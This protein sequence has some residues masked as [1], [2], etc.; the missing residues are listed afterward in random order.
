M[1]FMGLLHVFLPAFHSSAFSNP[2]QA[3]VHS[4]NERP[5]VLNPVQHQPWGDF[6]YTKLPLEEPRE[7]LPDTARPL[8]APRWFFGVESRKQIVDLFNASPLTDDQKTELLDPHNWQT[9]SNGFYVLPPP[10][11]VLEM[12][13]PARERIYGVLDDY[14]AN[15][16]QCHPFRFPAGGVEDWLADTGLGP[17]QSALF[18]RLLYTQ[19]D[20]LCF[21]DGAILQG[22]FSPADFSRLVKALYGERTFLMKLRITPETDI[23]ALIQYWDLSGNARAVRPLLESLAHLPGG[24]SI[25]VSALL[26]NFARSHLYTYAN[27][28]VDA[29]APLENCMWTA[30]NFFNDKP[31]DRFLNPSYVQSTLASDFYP[32]T[33]P[34]RFGD[35]I[36]VRSAT[37][38]M[39][40]L[41]VYL[42]DEVVFTKNGR[43]SIDPWVLMKMPDML[44]WYQTK[45]SRQVTVLRSKH[46]KR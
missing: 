34:P 27:P 43:D 29:A 18:R 36:A 30:M 21:C 22:L 20:S 40:H 15:S 33:C 5:A 32:V 42:A 10:K 46:L 41:C 8:G 45:N 17:E 12:T 38:G 9:V 16:L 7:F 39:I 23:D 2:S 28:A 25:N 4:R 26:P 37:G 6:E 1:A 35:L 44:A 3:N 24:G 14:P 19:G 13:Q 31:D 11:V